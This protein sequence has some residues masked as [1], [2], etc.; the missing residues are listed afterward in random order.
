MSTEVSTFASVGEV[1]DARAVTTVFQP[2]V[3]ID[4][5]HAPQTAEEKP[6]VVGMEAFA[7][8]PRHTPW[9]TPRAL[10]EAAHQVGRQAELDW[11][12][13]AGAYRSAIDNDLPDGV[14]LFVNAEPHTFGTPCPPDLAEVILAA[15]LRLRVVT[16]I[17][18]RAIADD[19][20]AV[21]AAGTACR[22]SGGGVALDDVGSYPGSLAMLTLLHPDVV[23][24]D[25]AAMKN[26]EHTMN[27]VRAY[28]ERSGAT[29]L[30]E[31][32][33]TEE[34]LATA[35]S[36]GATLGQGYLFDHPGPLQLVGNTL[37]RP[38]RTVPFV[39]APPAG[40]GSPRTPYEAISSVSPTAELTKRE[41]LD[42]TRLLEAR[43]MAVAEPAVLL[44]GF[45][46]ARHFTGA[47][48]RRYERHAQSSALVMALGTEVPSRP[49]LGV[50]GVALAADDP[51]RGEWDV[52]AVG[53]HF[54]AALVAR[55][56]GDDGP[57]LD[58][59]F[60]YTLTYDRELVLGAAQTLLHWI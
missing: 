51:L 7:R 5:R 38:R 57:D 20:L 55:D 18:E 2:I 56:L 44:S 4:P 3:R 8:G 25:L 31:G 17:P 49:A 10:F 54:V 27:A 15:Q 48:A 41:L 23:K 43:A 60:A 39:I 22:S 34:H 37:T 42:T 1:I 9:E 52:V 21:L 24:V 53:P 36:L 26:R 45:Q 28:A 11:I 46:E 32:I 29:I 33:E 47:T 19:P 35:L 6:E 30:A 14:T 13:R 50:H 40:G 12:C 59:R 58:R 16:E